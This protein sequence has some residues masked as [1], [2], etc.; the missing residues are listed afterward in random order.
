MGSILGNHLLGEAF[1]EAVGTALLVIEEDGIAVK[2]AGMTVVTKGPVPGTARVVV[3]DGADNVLDDE[4]EG[5][6][7]VL[8]YY[9]FFEHKYSM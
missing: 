7:V 3:E 6:C 9:Q 5:I 8:G 1:T 4:V 2:V